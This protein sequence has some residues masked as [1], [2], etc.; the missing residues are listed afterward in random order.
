MDQYLP[1]DV[2]SITKHLVQHVEHTAAKT[3]FNIKAP[4]LSK[5]LA[6]A[7]RDRLIV[8]YN[9]TNQKMAEA[10]PK[11]VWILSSEFL[12]GKMIGHM[13]LNVSLTE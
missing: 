3:R 8:L 4:D 5:A 2:K 7:L 10:N 12:F 1:H 11:R 13:L 6:R 9:D